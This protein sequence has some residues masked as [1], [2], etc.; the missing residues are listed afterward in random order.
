MHIVSVLATG[1]RQHLPGRGILAASNLQV[2]LSASLAGRSKSRLVRRMAS[3]F[4]RCPK[5]K[6]VAAS[7][8]LIVLQVA[9]KASR[10]VR[11][12]VRAHSSA[13]SSIC[14]NRGMNSTLKANFR[15]LQLRPLQAEHCQKSLDAQPHWIVCAAG[16]GFFMGNA[17]SDMVIK[18]QTSAV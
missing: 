3:T 16:F 14:A 13:K 2:S 5:P 1:V 17:A 18:R 11:G 15:A 7:C 10:A 4:C 8:R 9:F 12:K 6:N